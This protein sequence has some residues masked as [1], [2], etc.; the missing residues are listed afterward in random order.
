[1]R[2]FAQ[3]FLLFVL[4]AATASTGDVISY[5]RFEGNATDATG[6][7]NGE[8]IDFINPEVEGWSGDVFGP[9]IPLTGEAN[10]G[11]VRFAGGSE[12]IDLSNNN[13]L[14]LGTNFTIEFFL[15][16]DDPII[17]SPIFGF[18]P[19]SDLHF[20]LGVYS[21]DLVFRGEFQG[22]IDTL[23]SAPTMETGTWYHVALVLQPSEYSVYL[24]GSLLYNGALPSGGEGP[25]FFPGT[26]IT[27]DRTIGGES[28]TWRGYIDEF[29][30]SDDAL[31]PD[32]FLIAV[33]EPG[34]LFLCFTGFAALFL[35]WLK[36][37]FC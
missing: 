11:S 10:T 8:M 6:L 14:S 16:P 15:K 1:M 31:T 5:L 26:D 23:I 35:A 22:Q 19:L 37:Y 34:T 17:A 36:R 28:G 13:N 21:N 33:P 30:I 7:M 3:T 29:R 32:Q 4:L 20:L 12:F 2:G 9:T 27:G 24:D 25:Y 18:D